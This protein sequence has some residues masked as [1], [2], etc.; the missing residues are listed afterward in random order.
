MADALETLASMYQV[1]AWNDIPRIMV[2]RLD[3]P[4]HV[5][6]TKE[7]A[8]EKPW[9]YNIKH[10]LKTQEYPIGASN[11]DRKTLRRLDGSFF[12]S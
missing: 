8:N 11:K 5:F 9:Y 7:A 3:R 1:N 4:A 10:F 2:R 6:T 12:L